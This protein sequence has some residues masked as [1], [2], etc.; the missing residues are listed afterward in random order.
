M[1]E[2][3]RHERRVAVSSSNC[4]SHPS[5]AH[6]GEAWLWRHR[7]DPVASRHTGRLRHGNLETGHRTLAVFIHI[8]PL[9]WLVGLGPF[10][11]LG[12]LV[13]WL[14]GRERSVFI[15]DHGREAINFMLSFF[16]LHVILAITLIGIALWPVLWIVAIVNMI[17]AAVAAGQDEYFRYPVT[18]RFL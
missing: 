13:L 12:P 1:G 5:L 17:R 7:G 10:A 14:I 11:L 8:S 15:D 9:F 4:S 16:L 2:E 3:V 18:F 6:Y